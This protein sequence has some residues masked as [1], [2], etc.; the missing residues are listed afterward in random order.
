M[1]K[2]N[3]LGKTSDKTKRLSNL[4]RDLYSAKVHACIRNELLF[5]SSTRVHAQQEKNVVGASEVFNDT[6][7][8]FFS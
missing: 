3:L 7:R 2:K 6:S 1:G 5:L 4:R 8:L